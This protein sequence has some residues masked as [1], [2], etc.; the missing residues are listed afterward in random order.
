M[1]YTKLENRVCFFQANFFCQW[2]DTV[3]EYVYNKENDTVSE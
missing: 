1:E 2:I 3:S